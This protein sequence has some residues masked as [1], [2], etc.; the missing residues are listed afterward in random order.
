MKYG[1]IS[2]FI[3]ISMFMT[4]PASAETALEPWS[5]TQNFETRELMAW[6]SYPLWQDTAYDDNF[7][8]GNMITGDPNI[9][10]IVILHMR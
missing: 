5:Y 8:A 2:I 4:V 9:S 7:Y 1:I 6:A 3:F 10:I